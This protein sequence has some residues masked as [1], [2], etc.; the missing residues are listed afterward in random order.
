MIENILLNINL[1]AYIFTHIYIGA[2]TNKASD[3]YQD[4]LSRVASE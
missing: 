4:T 2:I 3:F 1:V